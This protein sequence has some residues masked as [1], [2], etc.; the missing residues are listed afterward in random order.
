VRVYEL[1]K[2]LNKET[3]D[4]L[5]ALEA[6][7]VSGKTHSSSI[8]QDAVTKVEAYVKAPPPPKQPAP[9]NVPP[10][11]AIQEPK[12]GRRGPIIL[13][14]AP[15][16]KPAPVQPPAP[17]PQPVEEPAKIQEV[18]PPKVEAFK[19]QAPKP[20]PR[21]PEAA[22]LPARSGTSAA[23]DVKKPES[24]KPGQKPP[25][26][27]GNIKS[28]PLTDR[29]TIDVVPPVDT[30]KPTRQEARK[31]VKKKRPEDADV[32]DGIKK[33]R[34]PS[35][36]PKEV[37]QKAGKVDLTAEILEEDVVLEPEKVD[38]QDVIIKRELQKR[39]KAKRE[40]EKKEA[41][42][43]PAAPQQPQISRP[44]P[45]TKKPKSR[46]RIRREKRDRF[47]RAV[48]EERQEMER[49]MRTLRITELT[50]VS[51][52]AENLGI[53]LSELIGKLM[54]MGLMVTKNQRLDSDT[55]HI[56]AAEYE[57]EVE[58]V[59]LVE[60]GFLQDYIDHS[61]GEERLRPPVVTV[62][63]H[64]DHGK[65]KL[66]DAI[67][68]TNVVAGESGG[69]TQHIGAYHVTLPSGQIV[70]LDT[71]GHET[72]TAMRA[73]GAMV[74]D[75]VVLVVSATEGVMPQTVEA[76]HHARA[77]DVSIIVAVNKV[78][79]PDANPDRIKQQLSEHGLL[80]DDWGGKTPFISISALKKTGIENLLEAILLEA[81]IL[82]KKACPSRLAMGTV[83]ESRV[84]R[85]QGSVATVLIQDGTLRT[86]D[87]FI[88]GL[89]P[90]KVR[91]L[92]DD[93]G[94]AIDEA[95]P[96]MPVEI[97]G[98]GGVPN[99]GDL[100]FVVEDEKIGRQLAIRLQAAQREKDIQKA[101]PITLEN[102]YS[103]VLEGQLKRLSLIVKGDVQGSVIALCD[104]LEK[105]SSEKVRLQVIHS[106]V[107]PVGVAD[108][109][110]AAASEALI[111]GFNVDMN[112]KVAEAAERENVEVRLYKII[113]DAINDIRNQMISM[114][115]KQY[116]EDVIGTFEVKQV[117]KA[118]KDSSVFGGVV[119][120]GKFVRQTPIKIY[121]GEELVFSGSLTNLKR[122]KE[123]VKEVPS[124]M[125]CGM[126]IDG[127]RDIQ[128]GDQ[129]QCIERREVQQ[130]L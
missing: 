40:A 106:A 81:E 47:E 103:R 128:V 53:P 1:A 16:P 28:R 66:L 36:V 107:G 77:A 80:S 91:A 113:Y 96:S 17:K 13:K 27:R 7:G 73:H 25:A 31:S 15:P 76:I 21:P 18:S 94:R 32:V 111:I 54:G 85:G 68:Q 99:S 23:I 92:L 41:P 45:G 24:K 93:Q 5:D 120:S 79:L 61:P 74:T 104:G 95:G 59:D 89:Y 64:V 118:S 14:P 35:R 121:R 109:M 11:T 38:A 86:G 26:G 116:A 56:I 78:D 43:A 46:D 97:L 52:V 65:T 87:P 114:L 71:P 6:V 2:K 117:F 8:T 124:G 30:G 49:A 70:F 112:P 63:G 83:I 75:I 108:V 20:T 29:L 42:K 126:S 44:T 10:T 9:V 127:L 58:E 3:K 102:L 39:K 62:M 110:L 125:E 129:V 88:C 119:T 51:D 100:F 122:F 69:I 90:G 57:F 4:V 98:L 72:F 115:D 55:I 67:R 105:L 84:D 101:R 60:D 12:P 34:L 130:T 19:P 123:D 82:E 33:E 48:E 22:E 50:T 37:K